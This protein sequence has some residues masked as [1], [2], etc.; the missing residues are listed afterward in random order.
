MKLVFL[1]ESFTI[2]A[3]YWSM[4]ENAIIILYSLNIIQHIELKFWKLFLLTMKRIFSPVLFSFLL[5]FWVLH[6]EP[7]PT[8]ERDSSTEE[9]LPPLTIEYL[10]PTSTFRLDESRFCNADAGTEDSNKVICRC[11][12]VNIRPIHTIYIQ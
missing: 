12:T 1:G 5:L 2:R 10:R 8:A 4:L 11:V 7:A 6:D 9:E 3:M